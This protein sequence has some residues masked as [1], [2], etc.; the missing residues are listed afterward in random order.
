MLFTNIKVYEGHVL[1]DYDSG[2]TCPRVLSIDAAIKP[3]DTLQFH[4]ELG[5][6]PR[7]HG[8]VVVRSPEDGST[9]WD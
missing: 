5:S 1:K 6:R 8:E 3:G 9:G 7:L 4:Y 2:L